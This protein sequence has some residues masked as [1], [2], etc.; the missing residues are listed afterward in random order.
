MYNLIKIFTKKKNESEEN[1]QD[2]SQEY[3]EDQDSEESDFYT[4]LVL[5]LKQNGEVLK[6]SQ[7]RLLCLVEVESFINSVQPFS[8]NREII[9][10]HKN[11]LVEVL[12]KQYKE[13]K[14]IEFFGLFEGFMTGSESIFLINGHHRYYALKEFMNNHK[15]DKYIMNKIKF[16]IFIF[17][18]LINSNIEEDERIIDLFKSINNSKE[19]RYEDLPVNIIYGAIKLLNEKFDD[20]IKSG[21]TVKKPFINKKDF[22]NLLKK[23]NI[24]LK[25]NTSDKLFKKLVRINDDYSSKTLRDFF[26]KINSSREKEFKKAQEK[27]FYLGLL[28]LDDII[29][30]YDEK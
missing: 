5:L 19:V 18:D 11:K 28:D 8:Y 3:Q 20:C 14:P 15:D 23:K 17:D 30:D 6:E 25:Y 16:E 7:N 13:N 9:K 1:Q 26:E 12:E 24:H 29:E 4:D 10:T 27:K 21:D 2:I 22:Y